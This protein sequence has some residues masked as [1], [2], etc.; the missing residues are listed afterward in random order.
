MRPGK[1]ATRVGGVHRLD[2]QR[3]A[4][5]EQAGVVGVFRIGE[6]VVNRA[7]ERDFRFS[8]LT[9]ANL[10]FTNLDGVNFEGAGT[11]GT[12]LNQCSNHDS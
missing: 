4:N 3:S 5:A 7:H 1:D 11:W 9:Y 2:V 8:I 12:N 6:G 10:S